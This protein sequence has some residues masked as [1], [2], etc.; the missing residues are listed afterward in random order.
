[1]KDRQPVSLSAARVSLDSSRVCSSSAENPRKPSLKKCVIV[2]TP[3]LLTLAVALGGCGSKNGN[4]EPQPANPPGITSPAGDKPIVQFS[5]DEPKTPTPTTVATVKPKPTE[6]PKQI[7]VAQPEK[8]LKEGWKR[9]TRKDYTVDYP[10]TWVAERMEDAPLQANRQPFDL[11]LAPKKETSKIQTMISLVYYVLDD[12]ISSLEKFV[13]EVR[14]SMQ[15]KFKERMLNVNGANVIDFI[16]EAAPNGRDY[17]ALY[18]VFLN[19][20][21]K[22]VYYLATQPYGEKTIEEILSSVQFKSVPNL[23]QA[24]NPAIKIENAKNPE[25]GWKRFIGREYTLDYP[26]AWYPVDKRTY[27]SFTLPDKVDSA[28]LDDDP[29]KRFQANIT[30]GVTI[31][32]YP[33]DDW[34]A[35]GKGLDWKTLDNYGIQLE[36]QLGSKYVDKKAYEMTYPDG[37]NRRALK[38]SARDNSGAVAY[39][40]FSSPDGSKIYEIVAVPENNL[41]VTKLVQSFKFTK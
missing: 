29:N 19:T 27:S 14:Q 15:V 8:P 3:A 20:G 6:A 2:F 35:K 33:S 23:N 30:A 32:T 4:S 10:E 36:N 1:M 22:D 18:R 37:K 28:F 13:S 26:G 39:Y 17:E 24:E 41:E 25:Q 7:Q 40:I 16:M 21:T 31:N 34:G 11:N 9:I 5:W 12:K 38:I